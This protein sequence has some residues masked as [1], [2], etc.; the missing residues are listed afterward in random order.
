MTAK[1]SL[2][3]VLLPGLDGTG[4]LFEPLLAALPSSIRTQVVAYPPDQ[5]LSL[6]EYAALV[7][8]LL[9]KGDVVLL[10]ES[11]SGLVALSLLVEGVALSR[12]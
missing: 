5:S 1:K 2:T 3:L 6:A 10:A 4:L 8:K 11:F 7:R 9:P 12:R